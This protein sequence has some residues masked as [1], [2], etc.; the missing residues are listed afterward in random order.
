[1]VKFQLR[2]EEHSL[3]WMCVL[4]IELAAAYPTLD[5]DD[6]HFDRDFPRH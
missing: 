6:K 2:L 3:G 1:M 4:P 5:D